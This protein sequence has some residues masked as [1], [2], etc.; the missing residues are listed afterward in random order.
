MKSRRMKTFQAW[1]VVHRDDALPWCTNHS[2][3]DT[4][5]QIYEFKE[6]RGLPMRIDQRWARVTVREVVGKKR[7]VRK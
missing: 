5:M 3:N 2:F 7:K 6:E 4:P 1:A